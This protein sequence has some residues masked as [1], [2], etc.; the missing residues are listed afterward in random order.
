MS[1]KKYADANGLSEFWNNT[2]NLHV[3]LTQAEY[4]ALTPD[5]STLYF[6]KG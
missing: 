6:I 4:D 3:E 2:K 5:T 1:V